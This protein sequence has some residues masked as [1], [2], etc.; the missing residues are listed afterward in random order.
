VN[1]AQTGFVA[2]RISL[3][4]FGL[5]LSACATQTQTD[6]PTS[7]EPISLP[8]DIVPSASATSIQTD[9][10]IPIASP[11]I[12]P[13]TEICSPLSEHDLARIEDYVSHPFTEA[14]GSN[15]ETGHH[16]LDF[17]YFRKDGVGP[18]IDG[19]PIQS[20]L[21][22]RVAGLGF[23]RLPYGNMLVIE[24]AFENLPPEL[25]ALYDMQA[26][27]SLYLLYAHMLENPAL[28]M[29][30][31]VDCAQ[32]IGNV[33]GSGFSG[34]PHLHLETRV[35]PSDLI[36]PTMIFYETTATLEEQEAYQAWR[37][38][39]PFELFNPLLLLT[40]PQDSNGD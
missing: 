8:T 3:M 31:Q 6:Q 32:I 17:S 20:V 9:T 33:G 1:L 7:T 39:G 13:K 2:Q 12:V 35:G 30:Q 21:N 23:D 26:G 10:P 40:F 15:L 18:P 22:G 25:T 4:L 28:P 36:L 34:N 27:S 29:G 24:T 11:A 14:I 38:A 16:G 5:L 37:F 19:N